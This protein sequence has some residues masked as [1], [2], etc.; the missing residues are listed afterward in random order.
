MEGLR[1]MFKGKGKGKGASS[2]HPI[3]RQ[4]D[5]TDYTRIDKTVFFND[6]SLDDEI[7]SAIQPDINLEDNPDY[8]PTNLDDKSTS[9]S[10]TETG[11]PHIPPSMRRGS[12]P[13]NLDDKPTRCRICKN[14]YKF[15]MGKVKV[16]WEVY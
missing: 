5:L 7:Y 13:T 6:I 1:G 8:T 3:P 12:T 16:R 9:A 14:I 10:Q 15:K 11:T 4:D 2:S